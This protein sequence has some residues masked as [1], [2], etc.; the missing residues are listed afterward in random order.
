MKEEE[1]SLRVHL[2]P[3]VGLLTGPSF[4]PCIVAV[5]RT[6]LHR[7]FLGQ[8]GPSW[9]LIVAPSSAPSSLTRP[10]CE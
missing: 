5:H 3:L 4:A 10:F 8:S 1:E 9:P 2:R 6:R 7:D